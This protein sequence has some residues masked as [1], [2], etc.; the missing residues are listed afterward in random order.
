MPLAV[1]A[2]NSVVC[3]FNPT[4]ISKTTKI[5]NRDEDIVLEVKL[6]RDNCNI[7]FLPKIQLHIIY[8]PIISGKAGDVYS[9]DIDSGANYVPGTSIE[10]RENAKSLATIADETKLDGYRFV[11]SGVKSLD[12]RFKISSVAS[13]PTCVA[14]A[15]RTCTAGAPPA[16]GNESDIK[17]NVNAGQFQA[18]VGPPIY[19]TLEGLT[20]NKSGFV[21]MR[22]ASLNQELKFV[23]TADRNGL[24]DTRSLGDEYLP[25]ESDIAEDW[26]A[27]AN[28]D[29]KPVANTVEFKITKKNTTKEN[30]EN[31]NQAS[32]GGSESEPI[33]FSIKIPNLLAGKAENLRE[34]VDYVLSNVLKFVIP[35]ATIFI[36]L[37]GVKLLI[38]PIMGLLGRR[39]F[40]TK[41]VYESIAMILIGLAVIFIGR[42]FVT[43]ILSL[44]GGLKS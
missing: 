6:P 21:L 3:S 40:E 20:P 22:S 15:N 34:L 32:G 25:G 35:L 28:I 37:Q 9:L 26:I 2:Q 5:N 23:F 16:S 41:E 31:G 42:G 18:D 12:E 14:F 33:A 38:N 17:L 13:N 30:S 7:N 43:L 39:E 44:L 1:S 36:V 24:A 10:I 29:N 4:L 19:F 11:V 8:T 27:R